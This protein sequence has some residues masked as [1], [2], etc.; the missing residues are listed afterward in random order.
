MPT[1]VASNGEATVFL[2]FLAGLP[3]AALAFR[4]WQ[5][6][7][8][9]RVKDDLAWLVPGGDDLE[10]GTTI[11]K[12]LTLAVVAVLLLHPLVWVSVSGIPG[13]DP[14]VLVAPE[15]SG[16]WGPAALQGALQAASVGAS[17]WL[18]A[19]PTANLR[20]TLT[21]TSDRLG[22]AEGTDWASFLLSG[23]PSRI[24]ERSL[25]SLML[26]ALLLGFGVATA[27]VTQ[28]TLGAVLAAAAVAFILSASLGWPTW[29]LMRAL[30][31]GSLRLRNEIERHLLDQAGWELS[32]SQ[33]PLDLELGCR[34]ECA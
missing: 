17:F 7:T 8:H 16:T 9:E 12:G 14:P 25:R 18:V 5:S 21:W 28:T 13:L 1:S 22:D 4:R 6:G 31:A 11:V 2:A 19:G 27:L 15:G 24:V 3:V 23:A 26:L 34:T 33:D 20:A 30:E 32:P 10:A 29:K